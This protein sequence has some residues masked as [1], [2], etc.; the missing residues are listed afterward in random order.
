MTAY[1]HRLLGQG[2][3]T[4]TGLLWRAAAMP[5]GG[6]CGAAAAGAAPP[7]PTVAVLT[8]SA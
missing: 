5:T 4:E 6:M 8:E 1:R 2:D 7:P 3:M